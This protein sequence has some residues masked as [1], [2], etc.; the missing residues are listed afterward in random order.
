MS[1]PPFEHDVQLR[2]PDVRKARDAARLR[3]D[4]DARRRCSTRSSPGSAPRWRPAGCDAGSCPSCTTP[5]STSARSARRTRSGARSSRFLAALHRPGRPGPRPRLRPRPLH[6]LGPRRPSAGRRTSA[7]CAPRCR[8]DVRFVQASGL[9]LADVD[10]DRPLRDRLHEQL[11]RAPRVERCRHRAAAG[12][13]P[14][15]SARAV[16]SIVLQPNIRL[17]GPRYWDFIDHKVALTE[18]SLLEA[19]ELAELAHGRADHPLPAVLDE[20]PAAD[21]TRGWSAPTCASGRRGGSSGGRRCS[22][23]ERARVTG[24]RSCR[25]SCPSSRRARPSSPSLR[26][27]IARRPRRRHEILVVYDFDED[28]TVPVDRRGSAAELPAVRGLSQRPR[29]RRAQRDEG[30]DRRHRAAPYVL[31]T[32][33]DGSDEPHVVDPMVALARDGAD[34]VAASRYMRGGRQIGGPLLKRLMSRTAGLTL[35]WFAGVPTHDPT[36]NFKLYARRFLDAVTIESTAGFELA[37]ELTVKATLAGRRVAEVPTTW[38]DRTAGQSNFKLRKWLPHYLHWYRAGVRRSLVRGRPPGSAM[39]ERL[40]TGAR[41]GRPAG[42]VRRDR[43]AVDRQAGRARRSTRATTRARP[44]AWLA[45]GDPWAV[46]ESGIPYAV[47]AAHPA[48]LRADQPAAARPS[49]PG[50]WMAGRR[51]RCGLARPS[52]RIAALVA[53]RSRPLLHGM[54]NGNPQTIALRPPRA[55]QPRSAAVAAVGLK[56]YAALPLLTRW[57]QLV[58][59]RASSLAAVTLRSCRGSCTSTAGWASGAIS[60]RPGTAARGGCPLLDPADAR[61]PVDP[62]PPGRRVVRGPGPLPG[63]PV[64]LRRDGAAG[65]RRAAGRGRAARG[66]DGAHGRRSS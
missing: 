3:G 22:S 43:R 7:T 6:P 60:R 34:V 1:D 2:V 29:P 16:A 66:A 32:M 35:H 30:R 39:I 58:D 54:W 11:P 12:R 62:A 48:L 26:A 21:A 61:R 53:G 28:P 63:D 19:A 25:S 49:R 50:L 59:R 65:P 51:R 14:S 9:D 23:A 56:L 27:L 47:G 5:G 24:R 40:S 8:H 36:N 13:A 38:R 33:A 15:C 55:G 31:I 42:L 20:G 45:G 18:R 46:T 17:V 37:L 64:L 4:D 10:P 41:A 57:R 44:T 52:P